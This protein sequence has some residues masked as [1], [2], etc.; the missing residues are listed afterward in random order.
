MS[1]S[2]VTP[3]TVASQASL[4]IGI[5][6]ARILEWVAVFCRRGSSW[7]SNQ[8]CVCLLHWQAG[9]L[10]RC[11][12]ESPVSPQI[13]AKIARTVAD[14]V[15]S[16][17]V[18]SLGDISK[19]KKTLLFVF[20][21]F[22]CSGFCHTLKWNSHGFTCVPHPDP[23]S[24]LPLHPLPLGLPGAPGPSACLMHP[25]LAGDLFYPR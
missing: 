12:L 5:F 13:I 8:T 17:I 20:F 15:S 7:P 4:S 2:F 25:T 22:Y 11:P 24:Y 23:P 18:S 3:W 9:S 6:Q 19:Y 16:R 14:W 1:D 10:P 21:F